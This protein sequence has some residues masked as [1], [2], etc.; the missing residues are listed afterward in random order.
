MG[1]LPLYSVKA[2]PEFREGNLGLWY[3][4]FYHNWTDTWGHLGDSQG[5]ASWIEATVHLKPSGDLLEEYVDRML[6]LIHD[7]T[8]KIAVYRTMDSFV[9]GLGRA[10][11][12]ENG[13]AWHHL[14]GVPFLPASSIKGL[15]RAWNQLE[16]GGRDERKLFGSGDQV[17]T[18][19][20]LDAIPVSVPALKYD[21]M[22]PHYNPYYQNQEV[23]GDWHNPT[24]I[25]FLS[26]AADQNFLFGILGHDKD[27][28]MV[29]DM[30][31]EALLWAG[32]G[33]KTAGGYGRFERWHAS[34]RELHARIDR[35]IREEAMQRQV[36]TMT[37]VERVMWDEGYESDPD[38]F[39]G[40]IDQRWI[41]RMQDA[42]DPDRK[43]IAQLLGRWYQRFRHDHW[44][45]PNKKNAERVKII[46][47]ALAALEIEM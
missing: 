43:E 42:D 23:P 13:M 22:T 28:A 18:I 45:K 17:G 20:F 15:L 41:P 11:P 21:V 37:P 29:D 32:A 3:D 14:L 46:K 31:D 35:I 6:R 24:P 36:R 2:P 44:K 34:E 10:H 1:A 27:L 12:V 4:K 25:P 16:R 33:A 9:S 39:L 5:K 26:V 7:Q 40:L 8:G 30:L 19:K 47:S 38:K